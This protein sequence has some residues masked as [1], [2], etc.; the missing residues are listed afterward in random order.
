MNER[1][2]KA[3]KHS[4][5]HQ[6]PSHLDKYSSVKALQ[7]HCLP[8]DPPN[9]TAFT[10]YAHPRKHDLKENTKHQHNQ[11]HKEQPHHKNVLLQPRKSNQ[12]D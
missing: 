4:K 12:G 10:H 3:K 11:L 9:I 2:V 1:L 8:K 6:Q 7:P 5:G